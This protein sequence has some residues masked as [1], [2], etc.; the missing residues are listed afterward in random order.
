MRTHNKLTAARITSNP[1]PSAMAAPFPEVFVINLDDRRDRWTEIEKTCR[2]ANVAPVRIPAVKTSPGWHGSGLSHLKC[3]RAAKERNLPWVLILEDDAT[4]TPEA[5]DRFRGLLDY[6]WDNLGQWERFNGGPTFPP[7]PVLRILSRTPPLIYAN[8]YCVHFYLVHSG[9]YD[10]ILEWDPA[11][12][13]VIDVFLMNLESKFRTVFNSVATVPH[14]SLQ[15]TS[16]SDIS[17]DP[18]QSENDYS[19]YFYYSEEKLRECLEQCSTQKVDQ[20]RK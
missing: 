5:M 6:L 13:P 14:I 2:A 19:A 9:A 16:R 20:E 10:T 1:R 8:G 18:H 11:R 12:D 7:D 17:P 4:F 15:A 3:I